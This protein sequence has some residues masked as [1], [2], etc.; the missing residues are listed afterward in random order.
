MQKEGMM[1]KRRHRLLAFLLM[2]VLLVME[3][4][5]FV[6]AE[7]V[8]S[9]TEVQ[10]SVTETEIETET[11]QEQPQEQAP[12]TGEEENLPV[13]G[14]QAIGNFVGETLYFVDLNWESSYVSSVFAV[15]TD[16]AQEETR[17]AMTPQE[18]GRYAAVIPDG[19]YAAVGFEV[20]LQDGSIQN[21]E[22][23]SVEFYI[24]RRDTFYYGNAQEDSYW[25]A[26]ALYE[27]TNEQS[28]SLQAEG[29]AD[30]TGQ[31]VYF[32]DIPK[33]DVQQVKKV[34]AQFYMDRHEADTE[35]RAVR[36][37]EGRERI[38]SAPIPE[39]GYD[40]ITFLIE[41]ADQTSYQIKRHFNIQGTASSTDDRHEE[42]FQYEA[43]VMDTFFYNHVGQANMESMRDSYWGPHISRANRSLDSQTFYM[44]LNEKNG[45]DILLEKDSLR[46]RYTKTD[47]TTQEVNRFPETRQANVIYYQF[48]I[49]SGATEETVLEISGTLTT[50][51]EVSFK[52]Y[53]P[54]NSSKKM[55]LVDY[56]REGA[57][58]FGEFV[59]SEVSDAFY[60]SYDNKNTQFTNVQYRLKTE[61][62]RSWT[63]WANLEKTKPESWEDNTFFPIVEHV[64]GVQ[65]WQD[66]NDPYVYVQFRGTDSKEDWVTKFT[67]DTGNQWIDFGKKENPYLWRTTD[68]PNDTSRIPL[69]ELSYPCLVG[70]R[71]GEANTPTGTGVNI[72]GTWK[73]VLDVDNRGDS[74][75]TVPKGE[76]ETE[77]ST[78]YGSA[79]LYDYYSDREMQ[80][81]K[82][83]GDQNG[84][85]LDTSEML[86]L[87]ISEYS[88]QNQQTMSPI[89]MAGKAD[90]AKQLY[91]YEERTNKWSGKFHEVA[92]KGGQ[93][94]GIAKQ[95]L[96]DSSLTDGQ[97][98]QESH[99]VPLF[100][101]T[102]LR[103]GNEYGV[104]LGNVYKNVQFPFKKNEKTGYWEF[105]SA[106]GED[107]LSLYEDVDTGYF[108]K[109]TGIPITGM[110]SNGFFPLNTSNDEPRN[111]LFGSRIDIPFTLPEGN[112]VQMEENGEKVPVTF[113]FS[114]DDDTWIFIDG[115]LV[116]DIG[117]IH[118]AIKGSINFE[119]GMF[120]VERFTKKDGKIRQE[121][122]QTGKFNLDDT[123]KEHTLTMFYMERGQGA[124][125]MKI[126]FNFP[127][128][129]TLDVTNSIDTSGANPIFED[130]LSHIGSFDY[131]I[132]N[133]V[134]SGETLPVEESA[135]YIKSARHEEFDEISR[136]SQ[137]TS[138][139]KVTAGAV[140]KSF[141]EN[142]RYVLEMR[143][144]QSVHP[145]SS[146]E[147][148]K[149]GL[150]SVEKRSAMDV[151]TM[152]YLR[153]EAYNSSD[154]LD[155]AGESLYVSLRDT[156]DN[157]IGGW[158]HRL[159]Y[160]DGNNGVGSKNWN[161]L[162]LDLNKMTYQQNYTTGTLS[163]TF[164]RKSV[165]AVEFAT[166]RTEELYLDNLV[167][168]AQTEAV[169]Y[170]GFSVDDSQ[171]S[172]YGSVESQELEFANGA[173]YEHYNET[174][175]QA[176]YKMVEDGV[177]S[178]GDQ[179]TAKFLDKF[180]VG[181]YIQ[182][183][184]KNI[185]SRVFDTTWSILN[186][187]NRDVVD[188]NWLL[189]SR[190][191]SHTII[192]DGE[193]LNL[194]NIPG[195]CPSD[196]R[197]SIPYGDFRPERPK[198]AF[199][200]RDYIEPDNDEGKEIY[201]TAAFHNALKT[202]SI[203]IVKKLD[204]LEDQIKA[205][206]GAEFE[207]D[208]IYTDIA[209]MQ[210]E[211][212][213]IVQTVSVK[214]EWENGELVGRTTV[215]GIPAGTRYEIR[216]RQSNGLVLQKIEGQL[217]G[218]EGKDTDGTI[219]GVVQGQP[220]YVEAV[221]FGETAAVYTFT[222]TI[223][224]F[225]IEAVKI[226]DDEGYEENRPTSILIEL[227]RRP[228]NQPNAEW[229][230]VTKDFY[231][232]NLP[233][234]KLSEENNWTARSNEIPVLQNGT[235]YK[236]RIQEK[237]DPT[238]DGA[239]LE[240]YTAVY[241]DGEKYEDNGKQIEKF[242]VTNSVY[243]LRVVKDWKDGEDPARPTEITIQLQRAPE[244]S[245][246]FEDVGK[247][248]KL[249]VH[250]DPRW[251]YTYKGLEKLGPDGKPYQYRVLEQEMKNA[252]GDTVIT[253]D[254]SKGPAK[255]AGDYMISYESKPGE[256]KI[257]NT[258]D[259]GTVVIEKKSE[260]GKTL[261][262]GAKF[263]VERLKPKEGT[264]ED[265]SFETGKFNENWVVDEVYTVGTFVTGED[266][267]I[268]IKELPYGYYR[269]TEVQAPPGYVQLK[270]S[271]DFEIDREILDQA[272]QETG[273][274]YLLIEIKN[275][276][277]LD[278]PESGAGGIFGF[279]AAGL[280][281]MG[282]AIILYIRQK[283]KQE[284]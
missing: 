73:S 261:L 185:D 130:D 253:V 69:S 27:E 146:P 137:I 58:V 237:S 55:L 46:L 173:W 226:W 84:I 37:Y 92:G 42:A 40:E 179:Q 266:G 112:V 74:V 95:G 9:H 87:A 256:L 232:Q 198:E 282:A 168:Y 102:F 53:Y 44:D 269:L 61:N 219:D 52:F 108:L 117:G 176:K 43:G 101:E 85:N 103:G 215:T 38:F 121:K 6:Y 227:Q 143:E 70:E 132:S 229:E 140:P 17:V 195:I 197:T 122:A 8:P 62:G 174:V 254:N 41:Y 202:G 144:E 172:D 257:V 247:P 230:N 238:A 221:V 189:P 120:T 119:K 135:G 153:L 65:V 81:E 64:W 240:N 196:G 245:D 252:A 158:A 16:G 205:F 207:F 175:S 86:N 223:D 128:M 210:L 259:L 160:E 218:H 96:V 283:M 2:M 243:E 265:N 34:T 19:G 4:P 80:G 93:D 239:P 262:K 260:D 224:P 51:E 150:V 118:D 166:R 129:N 12:E 75:N 22:K 39:G 162:R 125:N 56:I 127:K 116:L 88:K 78:Y 124:S 97:L 79:T 211:Q 169:P 249:S 200:Y 14:E 177:F 157:R 45:N 7:E 47:G 30:L 248:Q 36:M 217:N 107:A 251:K 161:I 109:R 133:R 212:E 50:K 29:R 21:V 148:M 165:K 276:P 90:N 228:A 26:D 110:G 192:N 234:V 126:T 18:R 10:E 23:E 171:I 204:V 15:F 76:Y 163:T 231:G 278:V 20:T 152:R 270:Q 25:G 142:R 66:P 280:V 123:K 147:E 3:I 54:Y 182:I 155:T 271:V 67:K 60:L 48:P 277:K 264:V 263:K 98:T 190:T 68:S 206:D 32:V 184:Q 186:G 139:E 113:E 274:P 284:Q 258:K 71:E 99:P 233:E 225:Q 94:V 279:F 136:G 1:R 33:T 281:L 28:L 220:P 201:L 149:Q 59:A 138:G 170:H 272:E 111:Y 151:S 183:R 188:E 159:E 134:V 105:N 5:G 193:T 83:V 194:T 222:N 199:V 180:R 72:N 255:E 89:Y 244:G 131:E 213:Q 13:L 275:R 214:M 242:T 91:R 203:E 156:A 191:D 57:A 141:G 187:P 268:T 82:P 246:Q 236:Y 208:I 235:Y 11:E 145:G 273:N 209:G 106:R 114:G 115:Q 154:I 63:D 77:K 267:R 167:F 250:T 164:D 178:L 104:S 100:D 241:S 24:G 49:D 31:T 181:S 35:A 216:E